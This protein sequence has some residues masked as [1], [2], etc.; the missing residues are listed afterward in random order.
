MWLAYLLGWIGGLIVY[1]TNKDYDSRFHGAQS[2]LLS[3]AAFAVWLV[4][5]ILSAVLLS[6]LSFGLASILSLIGMLVLLAAFVLA[7][8]AAVQGSQGKRFK[9]PLIGDMAEK[10]AAK[11][12]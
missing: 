8:V 12:A 9:I 6:S 2:I 4:I 10:W 3:G 5:W 1:F 11:P 7:I